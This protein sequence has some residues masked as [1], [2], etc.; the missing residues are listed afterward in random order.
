MMPLRPG[1]PADVGGFRLVGRL[2]SGGMGQLYLGVR[3]GGSVVAVKL[4]RAELA[5]DPEFHARFGREIAAARKAVGRHTARIVEA[6]P[7]DSPPW[8]ATEYIPGPSMAEAVARFGPFAE[9]AARVLMAELCIGLTQLHEVGLVHRDLK[10]GN[11]LLTAD[12]PRIIDFGV[13][14]VLDASAITH[15]GQLVG[16]PGFMAPE[17]AIGGKSAS[18]AADIFALGAVVCFALTSSSP[19]GTGQTPAVVY[20]VVHEPPD[21]DGLPSSLREL[22]AACLEKDPAGRPTAGEVLGRLGPTDASTG[23]L[24][25]DVAADVRRRV[26]EL[27]KLRH[28]AVDTPTVLRARPSD[29]RAVG[30]NERPRRRRMVIAGAVFAGLAIIGVGAAVWDGWAPK[31][32]APIPTVAMIRASPSAAPSSTPATSPAARLSP[33]VVPSST[34]TTRTRVLPAV[35]QL[36]VPPPVVRPPHVQATTNKPKPTM[37]APTQRTA[38]RGLLLGSAMPIGG[39]DCLDTSISGGLELGER[40]VNAGGPNFTSDRCSAIYIRLTSGAYLTHA[41]SC[42]ETDD[43][44]T[45]IRCSGWVTLTGAGRWN[46]LS[47]AVEGGTRWRL[48][49]YAEKAES[50]RFYYTA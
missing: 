45:T 49:M 31:Q 21:L 48:E 38:I 15:T 46:T 23:W 16:S 27:E 20:R 3:S 18:P 4:I 13:S 30:G 9:P 33:S 25:D 10:P 37:R 12:G 42:L 6:D 43:G 36:V 34:E 39:G 40:T 11:V 19:F 29:A 7:E 26:A 28:E 17:Q 2:G 47:T 44:S 5:H 14:A 8:L 35:P 22:V 1:D 24:P 41:R 32:A 50:A